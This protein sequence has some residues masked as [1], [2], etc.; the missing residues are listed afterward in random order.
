[1]YFPA[2]LQGWF[3]DGDSFARIENMHEYI[4]PRLQIRFTMERGHVAVFWPDNRPFLSYRELG[5]L[6]QETAARVAEQQQRAEAER[7]RAEK[8]AAKLRELGID[9]DAV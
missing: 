4:S 5:V 3:R 7:A 1:L 2:H 9:P 6:Q 8:L